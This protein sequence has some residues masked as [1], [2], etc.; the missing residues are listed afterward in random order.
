MK[1]GKACDIYQLTV[2]QHLRY[3]G[4]SA[5]SQI[6]RLINLILNNIDSLSCVQIKLGIASSVYKGKRKPISQSNSYR[7]ITV[8]P[9]LGAIIDYFLDPIAEH[10]FRP[11]QSPDQVG[12]TSGIT[13]LL[14]ALQRGECQ[15]WAINKKLTCFGVSLD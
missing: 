1:L 6:L 8:T 7:R 2:E 13:Y 4:D 15:R 11:L 3:C 10:I 5:R 14:A 12:F 9:I